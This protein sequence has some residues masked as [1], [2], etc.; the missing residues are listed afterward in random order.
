ME[1]TDSVVKLTWDPNGTPL[2]LVDFGDP[3]WAIVTLDGQQLTHHQTFVR[4]AGA[5]VYPRGNESHSIAFELAADPAEIPAAMKAALDWMIAAPRTQADLQIE[6]DGITTIYTLHDCAV[7]RWSGGIEEC[8]V[9]R[10]LQIEGGA[11]T[12]AE[13]EPGP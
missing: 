10:R 8:L 6:I 12:A 1:L 4:A 11:L 2:V 3:M 5:K 13:P 7:P 9:R